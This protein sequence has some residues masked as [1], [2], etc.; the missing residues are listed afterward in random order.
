MGSSPAPL[1]PPRP[2]EPSGYW[3]PWDP[4]VCETTR[5]LKTLG[6]SPGQKEKI[7]CFPKSWWLEK[8]SPGWPQI[9]LFF[10]NLIQ[11]FKCSLQLKKY[12]NNSF[13]C[14][15]T[16]EPYY[17]HYYLLLLLLLLSWTPIL[18]SE[19]HHW[20]CSVAIIANTY[21]TPRCRLPHASS[22]KA[23]TDMVGIS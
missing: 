7:L 3:D 6:K 1:S 8:S 11:F 2:L 17:Y 16:K 22:E 10:I 9:Y 18:T 20:H 19:Q 13:L 21:F 5:I 4:H 14:R 15:K 12:S 23:N